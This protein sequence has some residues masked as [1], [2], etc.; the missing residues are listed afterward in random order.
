MSSP[1][2]GNEAAT[3][4]K[5]PDMA[6]W[7]LRLIIFGSLCYGDAKIDLD[8]L[9]TLAGIKKSS[10]SNYYRVKRRLEAL[11][12]DDAAAKD[13]TSSKHESSPTASPKKQRATKRR[14]T[15]SKTIVE[16]ENP[17]DAN[18]PEEQ[19]KLATNVAIIDYEPAE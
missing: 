4:A 1:E 6:P 7:E 11:V 10:A 2:K 8:K 17:E 3:A 9:A 5:L 19:E 15:V 14:K 13:G 12:D 16:P 18:Q